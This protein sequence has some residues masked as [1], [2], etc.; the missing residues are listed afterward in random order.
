MLKNILLN[1]LFKIFFTSDNSWPGIHFK[2]GWPASPPIFLT[3]ML[4]KYTV[5]TRLVRM[6]TIKLMSFLGFVQTERA[7]YPRER[8][9]QLF[10]S[11]PIIQIYFSIFFIKNTLIWSNFLNFLTFLSREILIWN[12]YTTNRLS[13]P[14]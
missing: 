1:M 7:Y 3:N 9:I 5:L 14:T 11:W 8:T 6:R 2:L 10:T 13:L 4:K 12:R